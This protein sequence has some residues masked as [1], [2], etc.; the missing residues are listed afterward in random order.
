MRR[1]QGGCRLVL[2]NRQLAKAAGEWVDGDFSI[3]QGQYLTLRRDFDGTELRFRFGPRT[4]CGPE[5]CY[6]RCLQRA[7]F[8]H[9]HPK[10]A[11]IVWSCSTDVH[12]I[13]ANIGLTNV[14]KVDS[15]ALP[16]AT[17]NLPDWI[18]DR[19]CDAALV[20]LAATTAGALTR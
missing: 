4:I 3:N 16:V 6:R 11:R 18:R 19:V 8:T 20:S 2:F 17:A 9:A 5:T 13:T 1:G 7:V 10:Q 12:W 15:F 14:P